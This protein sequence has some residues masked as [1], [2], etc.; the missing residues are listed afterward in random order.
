MKKL[1]LLSFALLLSVYSF[2]QRDTIPVHFATGQSVLTQG[3]QDQLTE[4]IYNDVLHTKQQIQIIGYTDYV[5][6]NQ[7]NDRLSKARANA[8]KRF[9]LDFGF[10]EKDIV[11]CIGKGEVTREG[12]TASGGFA[13]DRRVDIVTDAPTPEAF[14]PPPPPV[15]YPAPKEEK[16]AAPTPS[17]V[18]ATIPDLSKMKE[19]ETVV[20]QNIY[21]YPGRHAVKPE[22]ERTL[23]DLYK[24]MKAHQEVKIAIE[25]HVCCISEGA[26]DAL[27]FDTREIAL[28]LNR[29][30]AIYQYLIKRGISKDRLAYKGYGASH[31]I[32]WPEA[33]EEDADKNRRVELR[34][35]K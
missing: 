29:A 34:I 3:V 4:Y 17:P 35:I 14:L 19:N 6:G 5:G 20:L 18:P 24:A 22:S 21:F 31:R 9:L 16:E 23:D 30:K 26:P 7:Y 12:M 25:G 15:N 8:V 27:D 33:N 11:I 28:S 1:F 32:V 10:N 13:H 2:A